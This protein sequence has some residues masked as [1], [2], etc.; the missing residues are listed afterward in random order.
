MSRDDAEG[1]TFGCF[2][3]TRTFNGVP[4]RLTDHL[5]RLMDSAQFLMLKSPYSIQEISEQILK[6]VE[7]NRDLFAK[8]DWWITTK[9][10]PVSFHPEPFGKANLLVSMDRIPFEAR[11]D[12]VRT[13][14]CAAFSSIRRP[15]QD[16]YTPSAKA[17]CNYPNMH[18]AEH[19]VKQRDP[20]LV[21]FQMDSAGN[22][23]EG[24]G[25]NLFIVK[26]GKV[27]TPP[28]HMVL[29]GISRKTAVELC[30]KQG[31]P[32]EERA[33]TL[34]DVYGADEMFMTST[35]RCIFG[36]RMVDGRQIGNLTADH[37]Y[38]PV[39]LRLMEA[40][41]Q[42]TGCDFIA[43]YLHGDGRHC[44]LDATSTKAVPKNVRPAQALPQVAAV[45]SD[46][47]RSKL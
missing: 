47:A 42:L 5:Q 23:L 30:E 40:Y 11:K 31:I 14:M 25:A 27:V 1:F 15:S 24:D 6:L 10:C 4:F 37:P 39:T 9:L 21:C 18:F 41:K 7:A 43:Q 17:N 36:I 22:V 3:T 20:S 8:R 28:G 26:N 35:S 19:Q 45:A 32:L 16:T 33:L 13:G 38:G 34:Y 12:G 46:P 29:E 2:D 44:P